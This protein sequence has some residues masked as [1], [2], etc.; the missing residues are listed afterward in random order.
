MAAQR[1]EGYAMRISRGNQVLGQWSSVEVKERLASKN[2]LPIDT[3]YDEELS[4][5]LPLSELPVEPSSAAKPQKKATPPCY[6][7]SGL[8]FHIC[9]G[10]GRKI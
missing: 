8:P 7:G 6:C 2:L 5:W 4:E 1:A 3:F 9:C 10:D